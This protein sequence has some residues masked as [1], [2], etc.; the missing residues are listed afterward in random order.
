MQ[1]R[2]GRSAEGSCCLSP[3]LRDLQRLQLPRE[4]ERVGI[5]HGLVLLLRVVGRGV[6]ASATAQ[7]ARALNAD[8]GV[9]ALVGS[10][11]R[12]ERL[13]IRPLETSVAPK[14]GLDRT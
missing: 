3:L 13:P 6:M 1:M 14:E 9:G 4:E 10:A 5:V 7:P 11:D 8:D 2:G 12:V